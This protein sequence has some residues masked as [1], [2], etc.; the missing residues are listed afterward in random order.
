MLSLEFTVEGIGETMY[1]GIYEYTQGVNQMSL[2]IYN[3]ETHED[4]VVSKQGKHFSL[5][6]SVYLDEGTYYFVVK[7]DRAEVIG[8][9][10]QSPLQFQLDI[11]RHTIPSED[12]EYIVHQLETI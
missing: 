7:N 10:R 12:E 11:V 8:T 4:L 5:I 9:T 3:G 6:D 1:A 2:H